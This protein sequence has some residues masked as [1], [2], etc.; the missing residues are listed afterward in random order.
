M[1]RG[2][3]KTFGVRPYPDGLT[4]TIGTGRLDLSRVVDDKIETSIENTRSGRPEATE[5]GPC[6]RAVTRLKSPRIRAVTSWVRSSSVQES[7][8][9]C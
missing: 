2:P 3:V 5:Q 1:G 9:L 6:D 7:C 4:R 8:R